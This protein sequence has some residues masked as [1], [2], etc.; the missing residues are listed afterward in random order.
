MAGPRKRV[1]DKAQDGGASDVE[2]EEEKPGRRQT[3]TTRLSLQ[4]RD[5]AGE[6]TAVKAGNLSTTRVHWRGPH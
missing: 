3:R 2:D 6:Q 4:T 1:A 5:V